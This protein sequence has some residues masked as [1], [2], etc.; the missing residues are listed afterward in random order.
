MTQLKNIKILHTIFAFIGELYNKRSLI[1]S[2]SIRSFKSA[3]FGSILGMT[4]V[5]VEPLIYV[6]LLWFFFTKAMKFQPPE[7]YPF[8]PWLMA[9]LAL[10]NFISLTLSSSAS[11]FRSHSFLLKRPEFNMALLPIVNILTALYIHVIFLVILFVMLLVSNI[12]FTLYWFQAIYYLFAT[13][14]LLL[15]VAWIAASLSLF[16]KDVGNIIG[17]ILQIGFWISPIFWSVNT[18]PA[19]YRFLLQLNPLTYL[20]EGYRKSFLYGQAFWNDLHGFLYFWSFT[21]V[22]L[23]AGV[24]TYKRLRPHFG[25]VI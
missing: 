1:L 18:Y 22:V 4:W 20:L 8:V 24:F 5:L 25:D 14:V 3:Y 7:G 6:L 16:I 17:I 11:T 19:N 21:L 12:T 15:G 9:A 23:I 2:L 13:T 10:W